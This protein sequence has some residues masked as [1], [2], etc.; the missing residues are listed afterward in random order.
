[1]ESTD[2]EARAEL[3]R[4]VIALLD[5]WGAEPEEQ[6]ALL[7]MPAG[8]RSGEIRQHRQGKPLPPSAEVQE[9]V[10]HFLGIA[11][12]LRTSYPHNQAMGGIW[13]NRKNA[14]FDNRT[15]LDAMLEDGI[16]AIFSIR[17][18]LDCAYDW[19]V[20]KARHVKPG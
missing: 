1:M 17:T 20:D 16:G 9:R 7:A 10:D 15:P 6:V 3:A 8:T 2:P 11:D 19:Q 12:A 4:T 14:R 5:S 18:H 13:M